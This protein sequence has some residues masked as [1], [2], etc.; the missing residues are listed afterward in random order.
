MLSSYKTESNLAIFNQEFSI[1]FEENRKYLNSF[2]API[3]NFCTVFQN[4][5]L[6]SEIFVY[7]VFLMLAQPKVQTATT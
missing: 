7:L 4:Q 6:F 3:S 2:L 1:L 5:V